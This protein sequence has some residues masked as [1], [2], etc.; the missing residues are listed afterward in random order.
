LLADTMADVKK[1]TDEDIAG[2]NKA[3]NSAGIP[4]ISVIEVPPGRGR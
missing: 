4:F 1:V 3:L 2:L